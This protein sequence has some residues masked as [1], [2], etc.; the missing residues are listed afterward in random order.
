M[1]TN[2]PPTGTKT[3]PTP[4][5]DEQAAVIYAQLHPAE[6]ALKKKG[7]TYSRPLYT[8]LYQT[9]R[10]CGNPKCYRPINPDIECPLCTTQF[11]GKK[12]FNLIHVG[13]EGTTPEKGKLLS[14]CGTVNQTESVRNYLTT[15]F[16]QSIEPDA[17]LTVFAA[18]KLIQVLEEWLTQILFYGANYNTLSTLTSKEEIME[19]TK[20]IP[21]EQFVD[22]MAEDIRQYGMDIPDRETDETHIFFCACENVL[23]ELAGLVL[24]IFFASEVIHNSESRAQMIM[25]AVG[26]I[27]ASRPIELFEKAPFVGVS[28][29]IPDAVRPKFLVNQELASPWNIY[30]ADQKV[31]WPA[32]YYTFMLV[33]LGMPNQVVRRTMQFCVGLYVTAKDAMVIASAGT[34]TEGFGIISLLRAHASSDANRYVNHAATGAQHHMTSL[35][36]E[37]WI[38]R[39]EGVVVPDVDPKGDPDKGS[40]PV[41]REG[42]IRDLLAIGKKVKYP[43]P[44]PCYRIVTTRV[45]VNIV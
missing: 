12:C 23:Q 39:L 28:T 8:A 29:T 19:K 6:E 15:T 41:G 25:T 26:M 42:I 2:I 45:I 32:C 43:V 35:E 36:T 4:L 11:C 14:G 10:W 34:E 16:L 3:A 33:P 38:K 24:T 9:K 17:K 22:I 44:F 30:Q 20:L 7:L 13:K 27:H 1:T 40:S 5:S 18:Y 31:G 21:L 37:R